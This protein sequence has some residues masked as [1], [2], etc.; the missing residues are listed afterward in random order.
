MSQ[1]ERISDYPAHSLASAETALLTVWGSLRKYWDDLVLV[2]GLAVYHLTKREH[3]GLQ[4]TVTM[5]VDFG[6]ALAAGG[7]QYGTI[8]GDLAGLGFRLDKEKG[9][10]VREEN[11]VSLYIDFLTE[12]RS[13]HTG[14]IMVDDVVASVCPGVD[15]ALA[16]KRLVT[17]RGMDIYGQDQTYP[18]PMA[19]FGPLLV[20]KLNAFGGRTGRKHAKDAYD[21]LLMV[22]AGIDGQ[23]AAIKAFRA[24]ATKGNSGFADA[25]AA[26]RTYFT[27]P[28]QDG[29]IYAAACLFGANPSPELEP[30][31]RQIIQ[32]TVTV[33][34]RLLGR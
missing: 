27:A 5:D 2:G 8:T 16:C 1:Y 4:S 33:G 20:L 34:L 22:M 29:P 10:M 30:R 9:R 23:D 6:I 25:E 24:E 26:L 11:G 17:V 12:H 19:D 3:P 28:D 18:I 15:R 7:D 14:S 21:I 31:R 13:A 32:D